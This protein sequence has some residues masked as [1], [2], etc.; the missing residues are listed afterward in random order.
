MKII[1]RCFQEKFQ[2]Q[3][4]AASNEKGP[5]YA[6][7][8]NSATEKSKE[9]KYQE[10]ILAL[11]EAYQV[12]GIFI[13]I[14]LT[15]RISTYILTQHYVNSELRA[16]TFFFPF[17]SLKLSSFQLNWC[18]SCVRVSA[19]MNAKSMFYTYGYFGIRQYDA[20]LPGIDHLNGN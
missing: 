16:R 2:Q 5:S 4:G 9:Q 10:D 17:F 3:K 1:F 13:K 6:N 18:H 15:P 20:S 12:P 19:K 14:I 7:P 8:T 11:H